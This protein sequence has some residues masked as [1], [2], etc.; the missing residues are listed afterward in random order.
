MLDVA[1]LLVA[2]FLVGISVTGC[3]GGI[4]LKTKFKGIQ[5]NFLH[6]YLGV[7]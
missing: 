6:E 3:G 2:D 7:P 1:G 4:G 5:N